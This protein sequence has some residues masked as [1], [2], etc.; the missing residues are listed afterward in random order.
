LRPVGGGGPSLEVDRLHLIASLVNSRALELLS[1]YRV[2]RLALNLVDSDPVLKARTTR[3]RVAI[4]LYIVYRALGYSK[5]R[6]KLL[7]SKACRVSMK[8][9]ERVEKTYR[10]RVGELE[11]KARE[12]LERLARE[13][14][15][16]PIPLL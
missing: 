12:L 13:E 4:A 14:K 15:L 10:G 9:L 3:G 1:G 16:P 11:A 6:S 8:S 5:T 2:V 7:A